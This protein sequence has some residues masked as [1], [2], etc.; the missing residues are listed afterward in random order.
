M[1]LRCGTTM[2]LAQHPLVVLSFLGALALAKTSE[3]RGSHTNKGCFL[4]L[5]VKASRQE[6]TTHLNGPILKLCKSVALAL[7][8]NHCLGAFIFEELQT[9]VITNVEPSHPACTA[10]PFDDGSTSSSAEDSESRL[11]A[12]A[13]VCTRKQVPRAPTTC[14]APC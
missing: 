3:G 6:S 4:H 5:S 8:R 2:A 11:L 14:V 12:L 7:C 9:T 1:F 10:L 13:L